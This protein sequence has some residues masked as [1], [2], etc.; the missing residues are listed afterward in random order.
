MRAKRAK[1][2][3]RIPQRIE[4]LAERLRLTIASYGRVTTTAKAIRRSEGALRKWIRGSSE[5]TASDL[6]AICELTGT[7]IDWLIYG[8]SKTPPAPSGD[9]TRQ[10]GQH[11]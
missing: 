11:A 7:R 4:G 10:E 6:R 9:A 3:K 2:A 5:P 1:R 8:E